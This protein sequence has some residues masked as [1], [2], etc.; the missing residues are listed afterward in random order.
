[1]GIKTNRTSMQLAF[2][3]PP[4]SAQHE[5]YEQRLDSSESELETPK[6]L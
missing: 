3:A 1:M 4:L 5:G 2:I 6:S